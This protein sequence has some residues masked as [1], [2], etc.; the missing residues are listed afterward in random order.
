MS[1]GARLGDS[2]PRVLEG[3]AEQGDFEIRLRFAPEAAHLEV[4]GDV[5]LQSAPDLLAVLSAVVDSGRAS[6]TVDLSAVAFLDGRGL[7]VLVRGAARFESGRLALR[8]PSPMVRRLLDLTGLEQ[9]F[10]LGEDR[11]DEVRGHP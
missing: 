11:G 7:S 9:H 6:I 3:R 1:T 2:A 10:E 5:D 4:H 8:G